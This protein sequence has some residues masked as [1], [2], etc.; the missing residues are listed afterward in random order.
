MLG[1]HFAFRVILG[2]EWPVRHPVAEEN[3]MRDTKDVGSSPIPPSE[4]LR[5][6]ELLL[7]EN[8]IKTHRELD[9]LFSLEV[10]LQKDAD[11]FTRLNFLSSQG[12]PVERGLSPS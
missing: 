3:Q 5:A 11:R 12:I 8:A 1:V 2:K 10:T 9:H 6:V 7:S 4:Y